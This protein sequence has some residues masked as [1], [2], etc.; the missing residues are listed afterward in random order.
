MQV[1]LIVIGR[2]TI[3]FLVFSE[4]TNKELVVINTNDHGTECG[5]SSFFLYH[6]NL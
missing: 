1:Y 5:C 6:M 4:N 2:Y 3:Y